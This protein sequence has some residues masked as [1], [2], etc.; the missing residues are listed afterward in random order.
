MG[1]LLLKLRTW[2]ETADRTQR[3][4]TLFGGIFLVVLL[5]G[6][7]FFASRPKMT[8]AFGGLSPSEVGSVTAEIQKL[9]IPVEFDTQGNV[10]VPSSQLA[11]VRAKLAVAGKLP[12]TAHIG[13]EELGKL[14]MMN[15]PAVERERI[16]S[17]LEGE[18][19]RS[20][21]QIEGV[22]SA[23]VHITLGERT[24]FAAEKKPATASVVIHEKSG[25]IDQSSARA[26]AMMVSNGVPG[27]EPAKVFV[28]DNAG[29]ALYDGSEHASL[30]GMATQ[31][32][33]AER[34]E[35]LRRERDIQAKLDA[36]IGRGNSVVTVNV[37][38]DFDRETKEVSE[39]KPNKNP[40]YVEEATE[41]VGGGTS[42]TPIAS[43][44]GAND[45]TAPTE[46]AAPSTPNSNGYT[47]TKKMA[48]YPYTKTDAK[49]EK[50]IGG[51]KTLAVAVMVNEENVAD[52]TPVE[53]Y[54]QSYIGENAG[55]T[56][57]V[58]SMKFDTTLQEE[59]KKTAAAVAGQERMQQMVSLLPVAA[60]LIV[61]FVVLKAIAKAAKA[62]TVM[63]HA[64]PNGTLV[65]T[66]SGLGEAIVA[67]QEHHAGNHHEHTGG[68]GESARPLVRRNIGETEDV[69]DIEERMNRP[70]EQLKRM[71]HD[72]P[73]SVGLLIKSWMLE[74][75]R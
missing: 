45:P 35:A 2:W 53:E 55:F 42:T 4:V 21:E 20:I 22:E 44:V 75:R 17:I 31:K 24:A 71:A 12:A 57:S 39:L 56:A 9:G 15:T 63:I 29:R 66:P 30:G 47:G 7:F 19:S 23:R 69:G 54:L 70:L 28:V 3:A 37:E 34:A 46:T 6:T 5:G 65:S 60:L 18:L 50:A 10:L 38:M 40:L 43:G 14:G 36:V 72:R 8:M 13:N 32:L 1:A 16:K 52:P 49:T 74:E 11:E 26:I 62:Q 68:E 51:I 27:L 33:E 61:A 67:A 48:E 64:L 25:G 73:E 41:Q 59:A 58:T